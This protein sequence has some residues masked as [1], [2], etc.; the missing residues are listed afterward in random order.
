MAMKRV[1]FR[2][3]RRI[4]IFVSEGEEW[5][6]N[7]LYRALLELARREG[8]VGATVTHGIEGFGPELH[9]TTDRLPDIADHLPL[10]IEIIEHVER[11]EKLLSLLDVMV[12]R[13]MMT[14]SPI[15]IISSQE[16]Q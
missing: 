8:V 4:R 12:Q 9:L 10:Q 1:L 6:G 16:A 11:I 14:I 2:A 5:Q 15:E 3:G 13:G 7:P